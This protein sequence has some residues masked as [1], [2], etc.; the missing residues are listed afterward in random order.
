M[1]S[2]CAVLISTL[3]GFSVDITFVFVKILLIV[4]STVRS[5]MFLDPGIL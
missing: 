4:Q 5:Y 2:C 1:S 3:L